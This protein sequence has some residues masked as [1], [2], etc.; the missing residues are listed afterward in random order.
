MEHLKIEFN[1]WKVADLTTTTVYQISMLNKNIL[2]ALYFY[3]QFLLQVKVKPL[4]F[5]IKH[6]LNITSERGWMTSLYCGFDSDHSNDDFSEGG[7]GGHFCHKA[8]EEEPKA[9]S[10]RCA[11]IFK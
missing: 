3:S 1:V 11:R 2:T 6:V 5:F 7:G 8:V 4:L 10:R 9:V